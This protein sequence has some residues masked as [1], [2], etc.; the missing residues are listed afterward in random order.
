MPPSTNNPQQ[1]GREGRGGQQPT[2][3][4]GNT[5][6]ARRTQSRK[7][8]E[9]ARQRQVITL[10]SVAVGLALLVAIGGVLYQFVWVPSRTVA[11]VNATS[12]S[13]RDYWQE[14]RLSLAREIVQNLQLVALFGGQ[15]QFTQQFQGRSAAIDQQVRAIRS[16]PIDDATI[17]SWEDTQLTYQ[18]AAGLN[19]QA[20]DDEI[21]Q[22]L[23]QDL[24]RVVL[25]APVITPTDTI[26][27]TAT[28]AV[29]ATALVTPTT[30]PTATPGGPTATLAPSETPVPTSTPLPTPEAAQAS[31]DLPKIV[32]EVFSRYKQEIDQAAQ[33]T[34]LTEEDF[35]L[36]MHDQYRKQVIQEKVE[37]QLV[38]EAGFEASSDPTSLQA[39]QILLKVDA[40]AD[41][42]QEQ[43]D[44]LFAK[45]LPE[46][47]AIVARLRGGEDFATLAKE[48]SEDPG[49]KENGGSLGS[50][51]KDGKTESGAQFDPEFVKAALALQEHTI[52]DP[53]RTQ[54]GWHIITVT[55]RT[56]PTK[57]DQLR[58]KRTEALD[59]W[60]A[61]L[62]SKAQISRDTGTT[63]TPVA[64]TAPPA[65]TTPPTFVPGPPT[66]VPTTAPISDTNSLTNTG[67]LTNTQ[68]V[69]P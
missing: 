59:K 29:T 31:A 13:L 39:S 22:R 55:S 52:S 36:A 6:H 61:D 23:V 7:Q 53:V 60:V 24:G 66:A 42:T 21:N 38:P 2:K 28:P 26:S 68:P 30:G 14:R 49:S 15:Q 10:T 63:P 35:R 69:T 25:P 41:A 65:P 20:S 11:Q 43:K 48:V 37:A 3:P 64:P 58:T 50:F 8:R 33:Q 9:E 17:T 40:P 47:Q 18:G 12:L 34:V 57:E 46:A 67:T 1:P 56:V 5:V 19:I 27:G 54:F 16:A 44:A 32:A 45:R 62:R 4:Q 51:D